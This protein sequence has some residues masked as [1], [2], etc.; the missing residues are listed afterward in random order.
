MNVIQFDGGVFGENGNVQ[1][2]VHAPLPSFNP[3]PDQFPGAELTEKVVEP[4]ST[5]I[6]APA[7]NVAPPSPPGIPLAGATLDM[8]IA[9]ATGDKAETTE[10][11]EV[12]A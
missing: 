7:D 8:S 3:T 4:L 12:K 1:N 9:P 10:T 6:H 11:A 5:D 2:R